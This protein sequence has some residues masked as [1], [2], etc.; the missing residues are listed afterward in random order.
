MADKYMK[1]IKF[2]ENGDTY[3]PLPI[4][5]ASDDDS[6]MIVENGEWVKKKITNAEEVTY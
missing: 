5:T 3:Y 6:V 2:T 4:V 1:T